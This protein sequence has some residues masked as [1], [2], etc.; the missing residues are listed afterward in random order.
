MRIKAIIITDGAD[1]VI[2]GSNNETPK[3]MFTMLKPLWNFDPHTDKIKYVD[4]EIEVEELS[5][6]ELNDATNSD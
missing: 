3:K 4:Q 6:V 5:E 2:H 1:Y